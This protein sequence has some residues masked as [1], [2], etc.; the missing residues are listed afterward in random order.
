MPEAQNIFKLLEK[1]K[2][3]PPRLPVVRQGGYTTFFFGQ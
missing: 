3:C 1:E 2:L